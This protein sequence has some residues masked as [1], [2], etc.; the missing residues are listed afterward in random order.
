MSKYVTKKTGE[1][2]KTGDGGNTGKIGRW[3]D[4]KLGKSFKA[5]FV[6]S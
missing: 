3:E 4:K 1:K 6:F 2:A 5:L